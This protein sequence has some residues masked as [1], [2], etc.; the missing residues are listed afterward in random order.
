MLRDRDGQG[1]GMIENPE[2]IASG[3][4]RPTSTFLIDAESNLKRQRLASL[5]APEGDAMIAYS[6]GSQ[7][8]T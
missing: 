3:A 6:I 1:D 2:G 7:R 4:D 8:A 5:V